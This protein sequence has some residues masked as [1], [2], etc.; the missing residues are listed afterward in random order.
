MCGTLPLHEK[1]EEELAEWTGM[2]AAMVYGSGFLANTGAISAL[3]EPD[4]NVLFDRLDHAS[5]IDGVRLSGADWKRFKHND[6]AELEALL[7]ER[8]GN[9]FIVIDSVFSMDG[10]LAPVLAIKDLAVK[11]GAYLIVD[12][13]HALGVFGGGKGVCAEKNIKPDMITGTF[14]KAFGGYGGFV[15][16]SS[17]IKKFLV[18]SSRSF[19]F[20]TALPPACLGGAMKALSIIRE[21]KGLGK[22]LLSNALYFHG[23]L[24]DAGLSIPEFSSQIIPVIIGKNERATAAASMLWEEGI[25]A[26]AIRPPTV[27]QGTARL[28]LSVT[29][30]HSRQDLKTAAEKIASAAAKGGLI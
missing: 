2:E 10:D 28:R 13:A 15:A 29:L 7:K 17:A 9:N 24:K 6:T 21:E 18:S 8:T 14:S 4:D 19:I 11:Y 20:S 12:E 23:L 1:L 22:E 26:R 27:P 30:A 5:I 3:A 25:Y 16:C